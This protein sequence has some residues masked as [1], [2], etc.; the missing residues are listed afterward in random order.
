MEAHRLRAPARDGAM[1]SEPTLDQV[2]GVVSRNRA[3]LL[4]WDHDFQGRGADALRR[5][6]REDVLRL[7]RAHHERFGLGLPK[8]DLSGDDT[9]P[10]IVTGHQPE[11]YHPGVWAKN[12]A[13]AGLARRF[14]G[15][16]VNFVVDNDVPHAPSVRVPVPSGDGA[17]RWKLIE[18]DTW[19]GESP[20]EDW[21]VRDEACFASFPDR[22]RE[23]LGPSAAGAV[24][25]EFWPLVTRSS[26]VT[27]RVG[28]RFS[29]AR[30]ALEE[31]WG[32]ANFE[33]PLSQVCRSDAFLW[34]LC[35]VLAHAGRFRSVHN[36]ALADYR[37]RYGVRSTHHPVPALAERDGWCEVPFWAWREGEPRRRPLLV[38][39]RGTV[40]D[41]K[42]HGEGP[43]LAADLP[44]GPDREACCAVER[45]R[46]LAA[47][48]VRLRTRALTTT[49]YARLM[50]GDLFVH[51]IGGAKY[52]ELGD[53]IVREFFGLEPPGYLA[54]S[55]TAWPGL[56]VMP[57][58][59]ERMRAVASELRDLEFNPQRH[60]DIGSVKP[61]TSAAVEARASAVAMPQSTRRERIARF[62]AIREATAAIRPNVAERERHLREEADRIEEGLAWN[63]LAQ[64]RDVSFVA[65]QTTRLRSILTEVGGLA[66]G[67]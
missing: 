14:G 4:S 48:G 52:D 45:L 16:G 9:V 63:R 15:L 38:R 8:Q 60:L 21:A 31:E 22:L 20:Y 66:E 32:V 37:K 13:V 27:D 56:P 47:T 55:L 6:A 39:S 12:F 1:L 10:W 42:L 53:A 51:G 11:L 43:L 2:P 36:A 41:V 7:A 44:L 35:H 30:H 46:E 33:V 54:L 57:A 29:T 64:A 62:R 50:F 19:P 34:Y 28:L 3:S 23:A 65:H 24:I 25:N 59:G 17:L 61:E 58:T 49:M 67:P 18:F 5:A 26:K 40:L